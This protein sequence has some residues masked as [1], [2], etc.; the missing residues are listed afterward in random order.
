MGI[1][2]ARAGLVLALAALALPAGLVAAT[3]AGW[4]LRFHV[5]RDTRAWRDGS[6]GERATAR[7]LRRL[8]RHMQ[9]QR[10]RQ[11]RLW[12]PMRLVYPRAQ[13]AFLLTPQTCQRQRPA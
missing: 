13:W 7:M 4:R 5:S 8:H 1:R 3:A 6:R 9:R 10:A 11:Q 2:F 12:L